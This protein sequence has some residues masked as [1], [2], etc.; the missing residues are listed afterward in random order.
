MSYKLTCFPIRG[1]PE[2]IRLVLFVDQGIKF[3]DDRINTNDWPSMKSHFSGAILRHLARKH[4]NCFVRNLHT[5]Y[6]KMIYQ[7]YY[8]EKDS[9]IKDILSVELAK[10]EKL[11]VTRDDEKN[12]ILGDKISYVDFVLFEELDIHQILD[13]HCLDRF[14]LLKAYHQRMEDRPGLKEYCEQRN[15]AKILV[16]GNG[17][18]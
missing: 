9:Y 15:A 14:P 1:L 3:A 6:A 13:P 7:A 18:R 10:F 17:K 16:N 12:F 2:P 8:T 4:S 5:K 11:L